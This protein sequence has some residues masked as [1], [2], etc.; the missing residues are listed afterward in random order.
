M[1]WLIRPK[2]FSN[3][4]LHVAPATNGEITDG[5]SISATNISR[6]GIGFEER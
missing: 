2:R 6:P 1:T 5:S 4:N 3:R